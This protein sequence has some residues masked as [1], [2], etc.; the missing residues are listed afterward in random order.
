MR[1]HHT[2]VHDVPLS[3]RTCTGCG[4]EYYDPEAQRT[5]CDDC[6]PNTGEHNGNWKGGKARATCQSCGSEFAFYPSEKKGVFCPECVAESEEFLGTPYH[7]VNEP[8]RVRRNCENCDQE[9]SVLQSEMDRGRGRFG[10]HE[11]LCLWMSRDGAVTYNRGW[12][13]VKRRA[14]ERDGHACQNC[15]MTRGELGREPD[16]HLSDRSASSTTLKTPIRSTTSF[17]S[18]VA[19]THASSGRRPDPQSWILRYPRVSHNV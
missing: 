3:N 4:T 14:L 10:S 11:C 8:K 5:Y 13:V 19:A 12:S 1:Q 18:V 15:G 16:V 9:M 6:N 17:A 2:K 7:E